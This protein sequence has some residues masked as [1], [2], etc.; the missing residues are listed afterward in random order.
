[1]LKSPQKSFA[2]SAPLQSSVCPSLGVMTNSPELADAIDW[3]PSSS[4]LH[5]L[6][7]VNFF[8][9]AALS[10]FGAY[11]ALFLAD[12]G[13]TQQN[14]GF[15]LTAGGL[16]GLL[17]QVPGRELLD[18]IRSK[19]AAIALGAVMIAAGAVIIAIR[20]S[21]PWV[22]VAFLL[23]GVTGGSLAGRRCHQPRTGWPG[24]AW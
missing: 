14:I 1:M 18:I 13:W 22:L 4:S 6:D 3:R 8:T 21:F 17:S 7:A 12:Q 20:P 23:Q 15:V 5:A 16:A 10:S 11:I 19:P 2:S 9:A 24:W